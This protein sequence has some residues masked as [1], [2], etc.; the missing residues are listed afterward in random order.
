MEH[1]VGQVV[2]ICFGMQVG[3]SV[4]G[5]L[6][7]EKRRNRDVLAKPVSLRQHG[8]VEKRPGRSTVAIDERVIVPDPEMK[9]DG[10]DDR[11]YEGVSILPIGERAHP[12]QACLEFVGVR[13]AVEDFAIEVAHDDVV[14]PPPQPAGGVGV[15]ERIGGDD[16]LELRES[17][18]A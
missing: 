5:R 7:A 14:L 18:R 12:V 17:S 16:F 13:W 1:E 10:A 15:I 8:P 3:S 4:L 6:R 9:D 2:F 11:V